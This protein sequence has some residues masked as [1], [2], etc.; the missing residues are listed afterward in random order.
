MIDFP[1]YR[2]PPVVEVACSLQYAPVAQMRLAHVGRYWAAIQDAFPLVDEKLPT[3]RVV[4][5]T[6]EAAAAEPR[7]IL[8]EQMPWP[9]TW[10]LEK[11][12]RRLIQ[13]QRDKFIYN[14][15]KL[16]PKDDYP[17]YDLIS[18]EFFEHWQGFLAFL[19]SL[20]LPSPVPDLC[21]LTYVNLIPRGQ[22]WGSVQEACGLFSFVDW[23]G[24]MGFLPLPSE[25]RCLLQFD[26]PRNSGRLRVD[27]SPAR[28]DV[29]GDL[30]VLRLTLVAR[31]G[32]AGQVTVDSLRSWFDLA[33][34]WIVKG[35]TD[36]VDRKTD[37]L[38]GREK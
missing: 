38:W 4:E 1:S 11:T 18:D 8:L 2:D 6:D 24:T 34:E 20:D 33:H 12:R 28:W 15:R 7:P 17:R 10:F 21:E 3:A 23:P 9:R 35:F 25:V 31:G 30:P 19:S 26:M 5:R 32:P 36:L 29:T 16:D 14:W 22:G 27:L 13:V 37:Q